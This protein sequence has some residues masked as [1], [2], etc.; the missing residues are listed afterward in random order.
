MFNNNRHLN[1]FE[2]YTQKG[3]LPIEN[4]VSRGL[5]ILLNQNSLVFDRFIDYVNTKCFEKKSSCMVPK[6]Q[7]INDKEIGIQQQIT[8]I[9]QSYPN[10]Y[11]IIGITLTTSSPINM[12]ENKYDDNN[13]LITDIVISCKDTL[14]VIEVKRNSVDARLQLKQQVKSI[15]TEVVRQ[16]GNLPDTELLDGTWEEIIAILQDVFNISGENKDSVLWHYLNHLENHYQQWFPISLLTDI[17]IDRENESAI[18]KRILS[19]IK[20]CCKNES[21]AEKYSGRYIIPLEYDFCTEAQLSMDYESKRLMITT[22]NGDTK[23]QSHCLLNKTNNDLSWVNENSLNIDGLKLDLFTEPYLRLAHF[24]STIMTE[25]FDKG[26]YQKNF[27]ISKDKCI[28]LYNDITREWKRPDWI[29][30]KALLKGKYNGLIEMNSFDSNFQSSFENSNRSYAH[31]SFGYETTVY[32]PLDV[33][34]KYE[35]DNSTLRNSDKLAWFISNV[36]NQLMK[37]IK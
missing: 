28:E 36:I 31:V 37:K 20:N 25:Y 33:I 17:L 9:V 2:H 22:W 30:F 10:P 12:A 8:K 27:G 4:N 24:Q 15:A 14:V 23:W 13:G 3:S 32:L 35:K 29:Q 19:L 21:D 5:A 11:N 7:R 18:D 6:P 16:G 26:Y 34:S 1:I